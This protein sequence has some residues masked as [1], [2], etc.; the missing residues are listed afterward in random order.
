MG[1]E[2]KTVYCIAYDAFS[3]ISYLHKNLM[4][5]LC[6]WCDLRNCCQLLKETNE[7]C[8]T[9][10]DQGIEVFP[11]AQYLI[12]INNT[13]QTR[14]KVKKNDDRVSGSKPRSVYGL[15]LQKNI[16]LDQKRI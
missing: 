7:Q 9:L 3:L 6:L 12:G 13:Q 5:N 15:N 1:N 4:I 16:E 8:Q 14:P 10:R 2:I 11:F